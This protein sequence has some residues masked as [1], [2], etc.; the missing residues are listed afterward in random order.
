M[1]PQ[2][3]PARDPEEGQDGDAQDDRPQPR[4]QQE[5]PDGL[6]A[7]DG[8]D[9]VEDVEAGDEG[10]A[11]G[12]DRPEHR[13][14]VGREDQRADL[15]EGERAQGGGERGQVLPRPQRGE[16]PG[17]EGA[18]APLAQDL[19][20]GEVE[21][22][23]GQLG[24]DDDRPP[25][26]RIPGD[27]EEDGADHQAREQGREP[28]PLRCLAPQVEH[29]GGGGAPHGGAA[30]GGGAP[31]PGPGHDSS[32]PVTEAKT[33]ARSASREWSARTRRVRSASWKEASSARPSSG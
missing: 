6:V 7:G 12:Q 1:A 8:D 3:P 28:V 32:R 26:A 2:P 16:G 4:G 20:G 33:S 11:E 17:G 22:G 29:E 10:R 15:G 31:R 14:A 30:A 9:A 27:R 24:Q 21:G 5:G 13:R 18:L 19:H 25:A 23:D